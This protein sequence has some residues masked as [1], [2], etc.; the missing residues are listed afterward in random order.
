MNHTMTL[1]I[2]RVEGA[3]IRALGL[4]ERRGFAVTSIDASADEAAQQMELTIEVRSPGRS[5]DVLARQI[6]KLFDVRSVDLVRTDEPAVQLEES[7]A[8]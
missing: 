2:Q 4:I 7:M 3:L 1:T 5:A 8:C 6:E